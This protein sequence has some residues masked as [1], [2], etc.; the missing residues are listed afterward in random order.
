LQA[1]T[2]WEGEVGKDN[3]EELAFELLDGLKTIAG[4]GHSVP[5][6]T[7]EFGKSLA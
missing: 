4:L 3:L 2:F 5:G 1:V 7:Q 6:L